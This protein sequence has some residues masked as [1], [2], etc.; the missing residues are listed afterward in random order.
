MKNDLCFKE[1]ES[2]SQEILCYLSEHPDA[3]DT[4][5]GIAEWWLLERKIRDQIALLREAIAGLVK[6]GLIIEQVIKNLKPRYKINSKKLKEVKRL[7]E[8]DTFRHKKKINS[9]RLNAAK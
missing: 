5:E 7:C 9:K 2:I 4:L 3:Q 1:R 6:R 8:E